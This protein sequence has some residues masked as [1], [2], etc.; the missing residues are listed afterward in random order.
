MKGKLF[1]LRLNE[2]LGALGVKLFTCFLIPANGFKMLVLCL[3]TLMLLCNL[4]PRQ[5]PV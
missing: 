3:V 4:Y 1:P 2:L 5:P